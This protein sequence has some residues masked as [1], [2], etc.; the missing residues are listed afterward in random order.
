[1]TD[2]VAIDLEAHRVCGV[3]ATVEPSSVRINR[4]FSLDVPESAQG[5]D[6][7][8]LGEWLRS[9]LKQARVSTSQAVVSLPREEVIVRHLEVPD[10]SDNELPDLVK[11]QAAAKSTIPLDQLTL[12]FLPLP[13]RPDASVREVLVATVHGD[14]VKHVRTAMR[15]AGLELE[16]I[17]VSSVSTAALVAEEELRMAHG[18]SELVVIIARHGDRVEISILG[19]G[20]LHFT[21]STQVDEKA[22]API[23][24][25]ISRSLVGLQKRLPNSKVVRCW[26][27]GSPDEASELGHAVKDRFSCEVKRLDPFRAKGVT[28]NCT[29]VDDPHGAFGG[30]I[31]QLFGRSQEVSRTV[32]FLQPRR[33]TEKKDYSQLK[34]IAVVA[35]AV[36]LFGALLGYRSYAVSGLQKKVAT[37]ERDE[38][39]SKALLKELEPQVKV[40]DSITEWSDRRVDWLG[41]ANLLAETLDGTERYYLTELKFGEGTRKEL[42]TVTAIGHARERFDVEGLNAQ[43]M[44]RSDLEVNARPIRK[45]GRDSEYPQQFD[46][47]LK[48]K[49]QETEQ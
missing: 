3:E 16:S 18:E 4:S 39:D 7:Q 27:I 26:L 11:F 15:A 41:E 12:D 45:S 14:R 47:D 29:P 35:A 33:P 24:A 38:M 32:D 22:H 8:A 6:S 31:G 25:E 20:H 48:L 5:E 36:L 9:E 1:M 40:A 2:F 43:L 42:G 37:A 19:N 44:Q 21:H 23:L 28:L 49:L 10:V 13:Q 34:R 30:P 17:G 46:L